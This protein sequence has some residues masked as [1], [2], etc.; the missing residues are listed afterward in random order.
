MKIDK[1]KFIKEV[2]KAIHFI[3]EFLLKLLDMLFEARIDSN[4][5]DEGWSLFINIKGKQPKTGIINNNF[6]IFDT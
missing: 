6:N 1:N 3:R 4:W 5:N 2:D